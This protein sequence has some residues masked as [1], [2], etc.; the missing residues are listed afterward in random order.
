M[1]GHVAA[2]GKG[3]AKAVGGLRGKAPV[4]ELGGFGSTS[5]LQLRNLNSLR[6]EKLLPRERQWYLLAKPRVLRKQKLWV[7]TLW[8]R[9]SLL[10]VGCSV[11]GPFCHHLWG[12]LLY[13][14]PHLPCAE[15]CEACTSPQCRTTY[16]KRNSCGS[17]C[18]HPFTKGS[19][20]L[21]SHLLSVEGLHHLKKWLQ[22]LN[23]W[24][25]CPIPLLNVLETRL[26]GSMA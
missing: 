8:L 2:K 19:I 6:R 25:L 14:L 20:L 18:C 5:S 15:V 9:F 11:V 23:P 1:L 17:C 21:V 7:T 26:D 24:L 3:A 13:V 16:C 22:V 4:L 10:R 12:Q